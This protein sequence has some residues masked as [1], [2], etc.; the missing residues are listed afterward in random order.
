MSSGSRVIWGN[1][2]DLNLGSIG[3]SWS[4]PGAR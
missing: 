4:K 3:M 1:L 2:Q